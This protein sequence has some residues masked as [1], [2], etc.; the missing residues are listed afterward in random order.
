MAIGYGGGAYQNS[1]RLVNRE[2]ENK[3]SF[4]RMMQMAALAS[5]M[6]GKTALGFGLG[7]LLANYLTRAREKMVDSRKDNVS[8]GG[9]GMTGEGTI[10]AGVSPAN[11]CISLGAPTTEEV[12]QAAASALNMPQVS[13]GSAYAFTPQAG[14]NPLNY[15]L[16]KLDWLNQKP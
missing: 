16:A 5:M 14:A 12:N 9:A 15:Q 4:D 6:N 7:G 3:N 13:G 11:L 10:S 1:Q 2:A 8:D